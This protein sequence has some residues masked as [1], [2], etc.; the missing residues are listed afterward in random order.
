MTLVQV[1]TPN[2]HSISGCKTSAQIIKVIGRLE[3]T[4]DMVINF[5]GRCSPPKTETCNLYCLNQK[6]S[7]IAK[8]LCLKDREVVEIQKTCGICPVSSTKLKKICNLYKCKGKDALTIQKDAKIP[9]L[10][11]KHVMAKKCSKCIIDDPALKKSI[12]LKSECSGHP[13]ARI[14]KAIALSESAVN[15]VLPKC[16]TI[17]PSCLKLI[18]ASVQRR[19]YEID[20][21]DVPAMN[22]AHIFDFKL[23]V[24]QEVLKTFKGK[25]SLYMHVFFCT[26]NMIEKLEES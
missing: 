1:N 9:L 15:G 17:V 10:T 22:L 20:C 11:V 13:V 21:F 3:L 24:I 2:L 23:Q 5:L 6:V 4:A 12:C 8:E 7:S 16:K 26:S 14:A 18:P 25:V 19:I